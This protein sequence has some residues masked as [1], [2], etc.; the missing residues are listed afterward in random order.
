VGREGIGE[1]TARQK[2]LRH[3]KNKNWGSSIEKNQFSPGLTELSRQRHA[4][5]CEFKVNLIYNVSTRTASAIHRK[6]KSQKGV[7][8][9]LQRQARVALDLQ[10][11]A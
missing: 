5:L 9:H 6:P 1:G 11:R 2:I 8:F 4:G 10:S 7:N 3:L